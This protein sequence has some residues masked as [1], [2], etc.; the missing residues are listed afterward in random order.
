MGELNLLQ[1]GHKLIL[2]PVKPIENVFSSFAAFLIK[3]WKSEVIALKKLGPYLSFQHTQ[4]YDG[5]S[6]SFLIKIPNTGLRDVFS[7]FPSRN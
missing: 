1:S 3:L 6:F 2:S 4:G 7:T 5:V